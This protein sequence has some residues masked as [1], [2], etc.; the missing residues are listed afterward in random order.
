MTESDVKIETPMKVGF[1][2]KLC[3]KNPEIKEVYVGI[4]TN[5]RNRKHHHNVRCNNPSKSN[6]KLPVYDF[7]RHNGGFHNWD[8]IQIERVEYNTKFELKSRERHYIELLNAKLNQRKIVDEKF[9]CECG[10][11]C[12]N[13][14]VEKHLK[15]KIHSE[16]MIG[17]NLCNEHGDA[18]HYS[19]TEIRNLMNNHNQLMSEIKNHI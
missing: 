19:T 17:I 3:C 2:Y 4:T 10:C 9:M 11:I 18:F 8:I 7:I 13:K 6:Y 1:V 16:N 12:T 5:L 14:T 15:S